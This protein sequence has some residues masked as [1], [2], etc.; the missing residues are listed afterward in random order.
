MTTET[1]KLGEEKTP[2]FKP[3][4]EDTSCLEMITQAVSGTPGILGV[5]IDSTEGRVSFDY[6]PRQVEEPRLEQIAQSIAPTVRHHLA[7]CTMRLGPRGGRACEACASVLEGK[8]NRLP[9]VNQASASYIGGVLSVKY[10][11]NLI[12]AD[13][14]L[15]SVQQF[16]VKVAPS[17]AELPGPAA[18]VAAS[19]NRFEQAWRWLAAQNLEAIFTAITLVA[20]ITGWLAESFWAAPLVSAAAYVLAYVF[21]GVYG[22]KGGLESLRHRTIDVDLLMVLAAL[23]AAIVGAPF[24]GALLLFLFSLSNVLQDYAMDRTRNAIR[25]LMKLR[26]DQALVRRGGRL[27]SLPVEKILVGDTFLLRPG[28]RIPLDGA[29]VDGE[30]SVDQSSITGE[31]MPVAKNVGDTL[32]AGTINKNGSLEARVTRLAKDSTIARLIR[33]VEE[34]QS[35]KAQTQRFLD[36]AEQYYAMGVIVFT[37]LVAAVPVLV[38]G[39]AFQGA[40]Y[41]AMTVMVAASPCALIISTPASI[42]SAIGNGARKGILFKGGVYIEQAAGIKVVAFDKT[43]TLTAGKPQVTDVVVLAG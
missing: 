14:L 1:K 8:V 41:R 24:E 29:V 33:L 6:D 28:D 12:S 23:G 30:S 18:V 40:F 25:A 7:T 13:Q 39:E 27:V 2:R 10:D 15:Q 36:K 3:E 9:G 21:G 34:A 5:Q 19:R 42:L 37:I 35:Q 32:L 11:H 38:F 31:S 16:G 43:G 22:V 20:M 17:S 4:E 26:P